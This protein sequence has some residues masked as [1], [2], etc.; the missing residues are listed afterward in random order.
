MKVFHVLFFVLLIHSFG[1]C[2]HVIVIDIDPV[3]SESAL[4]DSVYLAETESLPVP[5]LKPV[6]TPIPLNI[7]VYY[8]D[9][10]K[11]FEYI[12]GVPD[13]H[14]VVPLGEH[15]VEFFREVLPELFTSVIELDETELFTRDDVDIIIE[16]VIEEF[17]FR[18]GAERHS[19]L[20][21]I[22]YRFNIYQNNGVP[23]RVWRVHGQREFN[24]G[25]FQVV[26]THIKGDL[27]DAIEKIRLQSREVFDDQLIDVVKKK[28]SP[29][30]PSTVPAGVEIYLESQKTITLLNME[31]ELPGNV[32]VIKV[33]I[34]N[35]GK[36]NFILRG[37]E[38]RLILPNGHWVSPTGATQLIARALG[39]VDVN[40]AA[41]T[42]T[43]ADVLASMIHQFSESQERLSL[44]KAQV[45][46]LRSQQLRKTLI[47]HGASVTGLLSYLPVAG[48]PAFTGA[49]L[50]F[51]LYDTSSDETY[52]V[53]VPMTDFNFKGV[54]DKDALRKEL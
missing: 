54:A 5:E 40:V 11:N 34:H 13:I 27:A 7:G 4:D 51:W 21:S 37:S 42:V 29:F 41:T 39:P 24:L 44:L 50:Q 17:H 28:P 6:L 16:P 1:G 2:T 36:K 52:Q 3:Q 49:Q 30:I 43:V 32:A 10:L 12:R 45:T 33:S 20:H 48:T 31:K 26:W 8:S 25:I 23:L 14:W 18:L 38:T 9:E 53:R 35:Q 47:Q 15:S 46:Q 22:V 19:N